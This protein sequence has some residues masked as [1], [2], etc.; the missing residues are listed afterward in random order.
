MA[1][2][3]SSPSHTASLSSLCSARQTSTPPPLRLLTQHRH[4]GMGPQPPLPLPH[5]NRRPLPHPLPLPRLTTPPLTPP[6][7][8]PHRNLPLHPARPL[9]PALLG[10]NPRLP[11]RHRKLANPTKPLPPRPRRRLHCAHTLR[12]AQWTQPH[13]R[14]A[15]AHQ[16]RRHRRSHRRQIR[17]HPTRRCADELCQSAGRLVRQSVHVRVRHTQLDGSAKQEL[18]RRVLGPVYYC[19]AVADTTE[20]VSD[21]VCARAKGE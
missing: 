9:P 2:V 3:A 8:L 5:K 10:R 6:L 16:H 11:A 15:Q 7:L 13:A 12:L 1:S 14:D 17:R 19:G 21:R 4:L 18:R 20:T